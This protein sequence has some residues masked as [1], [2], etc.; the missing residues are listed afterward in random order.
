[1]VFFPEKES[2]LIQFALRADVMVMSAS[3]LKP[4]E[5]SNCNMEIDLPNIYPIHHAISL[6]QTNFYKTEDIY[7]EFI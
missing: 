2:D 3:P 7:R 4:L 5:S 6:D 1:M